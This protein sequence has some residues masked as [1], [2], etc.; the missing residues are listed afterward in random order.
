[1][2]GKDKDGGE[3]RVKE[4]STDHELHIHPALYFNCLFI[5][6]LILQPIPN[7]VSNFFAKN[8]K[9]EAS[10][11]SGVINTFTNDRKKIPHPGCKKS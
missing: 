3:G 9:K 8:G 7:S 10:L 5:L 1:V 4:G 2:N 6:F 11:L